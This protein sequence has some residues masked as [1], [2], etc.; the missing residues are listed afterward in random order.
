MTVADDLK[1]LVEEVYPETVANL[2]IMITQLGVQLTST[3]NE[4]IT[5]NDGVLDAATTDHLE[6]LEEIRVAN[7]WNQ[8]YTYE[9]DPGI[10]GYGITN[11]TDWY[12]LDYSGTPESANYYN[13]SAFSVT[14][15]SVYETGSLVKM[16][17]GSVVGTVDY[18]QDIPGIITRVYLTTPVVPPGISSADKSIPVYSPTL[19]WDNDP[20]L[21]LHQDN[22]LVGWNQL[23]QE[24]GVDG[25][26]GLYPREQQIGLGISVQ[27]KNRDAYQSFI[28]SYAPY[29]S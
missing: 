29:T 26:Y 20:T 21:T 23:N 8:V 1:I 16:Q 13:G 25:T 18:T 5:I 19:N 12:I 4:I 24:I 2:D 17:P 6:K 7:G 22:F 27:T 28:D 3:Q 11:L 10:D 14:Y 15:G 9:T